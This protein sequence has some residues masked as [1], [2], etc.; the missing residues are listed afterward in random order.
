MAGFILFIIACLIISIISTCH[1]NTCADPESFYQRGSKFDNVFFFFFFLVDDGIEDPNTAIIGPLSASQRNAI[2]MAD[3]GPNIEFWLGSLVVFRGSVPVLK[4]NPIF[5][6]FPEA[7]P[8]P[9][10]PTP[11]GSAHAI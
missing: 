9:L 1:I 6:D 3:D 7:G 2:L 5:C 11:S 4:G 10:S 8:D